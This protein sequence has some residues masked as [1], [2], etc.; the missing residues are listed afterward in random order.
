VSALVLHGI[1]TWG[2]DL[3]VVDVTR[4]ASGAS[5]Q[6]P[7]VR[8]HVGVLDENDLVQVGEFIVTSPD[9]AVIETAT[10][11]PVESG[12]V[13]ADS[14]LHRGAC[15]PDGL[16]AFFDRVNNWPHSQRIHV[17]LHHMDGRAENPG[18][19]RSRYLFWREGLPL[20]DL[21][22]DVLDGGRVIA[23]TDFAWDEHQLFGEFDGKEKYVRYLRPGENPGDAVFREKKREDL[24]RRITGWRFIRLT[25]ADLYHP[26]RTAASIRS[27]MRQAA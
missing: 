7:D 1:E 9:R 19:S 17:V 4:L 12:L 14:A 10:L 8:H 21:Q 13:S 5:R 27:M 25:W 16:R 11:V 6:Q 18:E 2:A 3:D 26:G 22:R 15:T 24:I 23:V 20:P